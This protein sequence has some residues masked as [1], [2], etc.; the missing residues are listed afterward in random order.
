LKFFS[1]VPENLSL[2]VSFV[3]LLGELI[4]MMWRKLLM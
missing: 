1:G 2:L 4:L 3:A